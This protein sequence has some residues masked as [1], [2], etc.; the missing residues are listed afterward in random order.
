MPCGVMMT[1]NS[2]TAAQQAYR[3]AGAS[4]QYNNALRTTSPVAMMAIAITR[5]RQHLRLAAQYRSEKKF[6]LEGREKAVVVTRLKALQACIAP[7]S[8][9][10]LSRDLF[11]FY[12]RMIKLLARNRRDA[13][14]EE[15][16]EVVDRNL[17]ELAREWEKF[18]KVDPSRTVQAQSGQT[19]I[20]TVL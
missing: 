2:A 9:P 17:Q 19:M 15:R 16:Y 8:A 10:E 12:A 3:Y 4:A 11:A 6:D 20:G 7:K 1:N 14:M 5:T 13:S 18:S